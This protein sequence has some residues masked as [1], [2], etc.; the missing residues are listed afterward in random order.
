MLLVL[1]ERLV[2]GMSLPQNP[3]RIFTFAP[4][5]FIYTPNLSCYKV[6][7]SLYYNMKFVF[8]NT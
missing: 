3:I 6:P 4:H 2:L 1:R 8:T 5:V 7:Q